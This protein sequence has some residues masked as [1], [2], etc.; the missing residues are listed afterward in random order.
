MVYNF[1]IGVAM[2]KKEENKIKKSKKNLTSKKNKKKVQK[3]A[4]P[5]VNREDIDKKVLQ[6]KL[7][8]LIGQLGGVKKMIDDGRVS[9]DLLMQL[10][11]VESGLESLKYMLYREVALKKLEKNNDN[12]F[13]VEIE[14]LLTTIRRY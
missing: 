4:R 5:V 9:E 12:N 14:E 8:R 3:P 13:D 2:K 10:C 7:N 6:T 11:A 1:N